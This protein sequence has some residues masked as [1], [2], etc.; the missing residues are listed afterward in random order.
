ELHRL[1]PRVLEAARGALALAEPD[2]GFLRLDRTAFA[3]APNIS[4][5]YAVME[6][7]GA[8]AVLPIDVGWSD[9]G[10]WSSLLDVAKRDKDGNSVHGDAVIHDSSNLYVHSERALVATI[11]VKDLVIVDTPDAL[12]VADKAR[13]QEVSGVVARLRASNRKEHEQ[14]LRNHR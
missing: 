5:D 12:L 4:V 11:G 1:E 8:A 7:T 3:T 6:K 2:L 13:S 10:S 9:V 14:H